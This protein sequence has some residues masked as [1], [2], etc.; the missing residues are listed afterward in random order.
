MV[1]ELARILTHAPVED[2]ELVE[3]QVHLAG[4]GMAELAGSGL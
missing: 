4:V 2:K 1:S 3:V